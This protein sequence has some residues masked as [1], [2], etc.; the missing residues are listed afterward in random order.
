MSAKKFPIFADRLNKLRTEVEIKTNN[1]KKK[2]CTLDEFSLILNEAKIKANDYN[3]II[4]SKSS[5]SKYE[6]GDQIPDIAHLYCICKAL[7][8]SADYLLGLSNAKNTALDVQAIS[9]A[10][11]LSDNA[12]SALQSSIKEKEENKQ[13]PNLVPGL[14][15]NNI[16]SDNQISYKH[17][18]VNAFFER[19]YYKI[20]FERIL[21]YINLDLMVPHTFHLDCSS[22]KSY[23]DVGLSP[24]QISKVQQQVNDIGNI[25]LDDINVEELLLQEIVRTLMICF[26][27]EN[28][29]SSDDEH[30]N[31]KVVVN[32]DK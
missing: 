29:R 21:Q 22:P 14:S 7:N 19:E 6:S 27:S 25:L 20:L 12:I 8:V 4:V 30:K 31:T 1:P 32:I 11:G 15:N 28:A 23:D 24:T 2:I 17:E 16:D 18:L 9:K 13:S 10:T 5:L 26:D 3:E